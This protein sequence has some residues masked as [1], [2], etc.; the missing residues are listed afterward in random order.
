MISGYYVYIM[1]N[2]RDNV[3][4]VGFT[5]DVYRRTIEHKEGIYEKAF[6]KRYNVS[7]LVYYEEHSDVEDA[8]RRERLIKRWKR[9]WK[10]DLITKFNPD[11]RDLFYDFIVK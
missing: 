9:K 6:S 5:N 2:R 1:S 7:K 11:W 4:Y 10:E 3:L 8:L